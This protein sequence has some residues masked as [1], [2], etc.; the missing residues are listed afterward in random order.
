VRADVTAWQEPRYSVR[1]TRGYCLPSKKLYQHIDKCDLFLLFWS[2]SAKQSK[3]VLEEVRYALR[4]KGGHQHARPQ[5]RPVI[6]AGPPA[7]TLPEELSDIH[8]NDILIYFMNEPR[9]SAGA[10]RD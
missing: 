1:I 3:W 7:P 9:R 5:I 4:R 6:I 2:T 8:F 10:A